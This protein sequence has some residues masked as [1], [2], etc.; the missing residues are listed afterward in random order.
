VR[1]TALNVVEKL[2]PV[3]G[4]SPTLQVS[5]PVDTIADADLSADIEAVLRESLTNV[6]RHA[7]AS[8]VDIELRAS[9]D[10]LL[11]AV[12]DDGRGLADEARSSGLANLRSRA[13]RR[14]GELDVCDRPEGGLSVRWTV[15]LRT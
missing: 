9:G 14:G 10:G 8:R 5:G 11:V 15:P 1:R 4:F 7:D 6:S 3:L 12:T 13:K 2:T